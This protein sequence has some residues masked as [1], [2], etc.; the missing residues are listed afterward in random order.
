M[1]NQEKQAEAFRDLSPERQ[2]AWASQEETQLFL[3]QLKVEREQVQQ[4]LDFACE[5]H[6]DALGR[7]ASLAHRGERH[8]LDYC[9]NTIEA[10][11]R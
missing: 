9:I 4:Q 7:E 1:G 8:R 2:K 11:L 10:A 3:A 6:A 5:P